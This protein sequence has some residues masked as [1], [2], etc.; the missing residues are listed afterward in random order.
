MSPS[1]LGTVAQFVVTFP[2][3]TGG[4]PLQITI[5]HLILAP[6]M[7]ENGIGGYVSAL[8]LF[9]VQCIGPKQAHLVV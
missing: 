6:S 2:L 5:K 7:R 4:V 1:Y 3:G 8:E 9:K